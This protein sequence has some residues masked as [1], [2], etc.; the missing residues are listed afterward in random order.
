ML[1][2]VPTA[3]AAELLVGDVPLADNG[4]AQFVLESESRDR[5]EG[6]EIRLGKDEY[7]ITHVSRLKLVGATRIGSSQEFAVFSSSFG[8]QTAVGQ[9]WVA[10]HR[11]HGCDQPYN[12]FLALYAVH[13]SEKAD[14]LGEIP[15]RGLVESV[16]ESDTSVVYCFMSAPA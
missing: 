15:Y 1:S 8:T 12:S 4:T 2:F 14:R 6:G 13:E 7:R 5:L 16:E 9:P 10:A 11:Y 3:G